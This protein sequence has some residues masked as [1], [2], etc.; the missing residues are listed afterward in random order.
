MSGPD[1]SKP[2]SFPP[3]MLHDGNIDEP[4]TEPELPVIPAGKARLALASA[5]LNLHRA[6]YD[7]ESTASAI[8]RQLDAQEEAST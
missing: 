8:A 2:P 3:R 7:V 4:T 6:V 5:L 1:D